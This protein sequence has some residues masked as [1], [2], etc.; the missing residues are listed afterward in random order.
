MH[1][2]EETMETEPTS[3]AMIATAPRVRSA[4]VQ[5]VDGAKVWKCRRVRSTR[6]SSNEGN[7]AYV[8]ISGE[9]Q[10]LGSVVQ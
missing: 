1:K 5:E 10:R 8:R 9:F 2:T 6:V 7:N 4:A 3:V